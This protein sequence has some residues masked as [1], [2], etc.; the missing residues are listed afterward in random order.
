MSS[1]FDKSFIRDFAENNKIPITELILKTLDKSKTKAT[2]LGICPISRSIVRSAIKICKLN[3]SPLMFVATLNQVDIDGGYTGWTQEEF[4]K[5]VGEEANKIGFDGPIIMALDHGGPWLKDK[6]VIESFTLEEAMEWMRKSI[7]ACLKAG[8]DLLHIDTTVDKELP[9]GRSPTIETVVKRAV[10]LIEYAESIREELDLHK[11]SYEVG[12]EE[13]LGG[14][15]DPN[16]LRR[17]LETFK[18][19]LRNKGLDNV[20]P[21]F[22]VANVGTYL[23]LDNKFDRGMAE[24]LVK[25]AKEYGSFIKGHFTDY[26]INPEEYPIAGVGGANIGPSL[27]HAEYDSLRKLEEAESKCAKKSGISNI[28]NISRILEKAIVESGRWKKWLKEDELG[29][30][31]YKLSSERR[32][33]LL[34]TCS[35]YILSE[36]TVDQARTK[37]FRNLEICGVDAEEE[38]INAIG[39]VIEKYVRSFNL[40]GI[41][42]VI[43]KILKEGVA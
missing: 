41:T 25:T 26:V 40:S 11:I 3:N 2:L 8:Y 5:F 18:K 23:R 35:R 37:L 14:I 12:T 36:K 13:V 43:E 9:K 21:C 20:W 24:K 17:Y 27:G 1:K 29:L 10:D 16:I 33:W 38:V 4:V 22:V 19:E 34:G 42:P 15:T 6:H 30:D 31:F 28:S 7:K 39:K 32:E